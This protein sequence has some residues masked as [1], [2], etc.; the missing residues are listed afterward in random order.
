MGGLWRKMPITAF[1][2]LVGVVAIS[3]LAIPGIAIFGEK[4][5]FSGFHSKDAIVATALAYSQLNSVHFLLFLVPLVT[6]GITAFYMFRLWFF[7]FAGEPRDQHVYDHAHESPWVMTGPLVLLSVFAA[8][9]AF[10]GED[11]ALYRTLWDSAPP[12]AQNGLM[13]GEA[14]IKLPA[15]EY[16]HGHMDAEGHH[17]HAAEGEHPPSPHAKAGT[18]A[19]LAAFGGF[20]LALALYGWRVVDPAEIGRS[21]SGVH[22]FLVEKWRFDELYDAMFV[23]PVHI[24]GSGVTW[25]D[26]RLFDGF[27]H[28]LAS[29]TVEVAKWDRK[30]DEGLIDGLVNWI[31]DV[32]R[33]FGGSLRGFQ[34]GSLRQYVMFI[35]VGVLTLF[36]LMFAFFPTA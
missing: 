19:L 16:V 20:A 33:S 6:A 31:G 29:G 23:R 36:V 21:L 32:V 11:G 24:V 4:I 8:F 26:R 7:T 12:V 28:G 1:T 17:V 22:T 9:V 15:P 3:G 27:L 18:Y 30:F 14:A 25:V 34:T 35:A 13:D 2:M 5:A 10:G